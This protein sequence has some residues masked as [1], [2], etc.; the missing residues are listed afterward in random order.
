MPT[1]AQRAEELRRLINYHN[2]KYY[3][4]AAPE[5][6][7]RE[8][9]RLLEDLRK[10][11]A[12]HPE[13]AT[14]DSPT[15]RV[16]G[17][18]IEGFRTVVHRV[19]MLSI[20][21]TY[22]ADDL[23]EFDKRVRKALGKEPVTYVVELKIDGVAIS[24]TYEDGL[25][26]VGATRG[27]GERG[28]DVTHNLK[29]VRDLPLRLHSDHPPSLFEVR[30]EIY[31]TRAELARI[32]RE[33]EQAGEEPY[34][35]PRNLA[36][37]TLKL[38]DPKLCAQRRL[39]L[40][41]Y[42]TGAVEGIELTTHRQMLALL[43]K[44]GF[45][46]NEHIR[47]FDAI[48]GVIDYAMS[49]ATKRN[50]L[51]YEIDGMV[52]KVDD[53]GQRRRL[54]F[55]SKFPRWAVAYKFPAEQAMTRLAEV[56][57][58]VGKSGVLTPRA[59]LDPPVRLAG[60]T[61]RHASLHNEDYMRSKDIRVGDMVVVEKAGEIIPYIVRSEPAARTGKEKIFH[62][63][64]RCPVCGAPVKKDKDGPFYRCTGQDCVGRLKRQLE[65]YAKRNAMDIQDLGEKVVAQL[66]DNGLVQSVPD[67][68]RLKKEDLV[69]LE[70]MG[71]KSAQ[72]LLDGIEASKERGLARLLAGLAIP[73]V[74][75]TVAD[76]LAQEFLSID[77][78]MQ[79]SV[80]RL[81]Q[82]KGIG[83]VIAQSVYDY[84]HSPTGQKVIEEL[85][86]LGVKLT[87]Q[88]RAKAKGG[89]DLTGKTF[90]VTGTLKNYERSEIEGLIRKLG[91]KA[92]GSV[93]KKT[94]Y[95]VAGEAAG[96]KLTKARELG[97]PVLT[98]E[99]FEKLIGK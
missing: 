77:A 68:Y 56:E 73:H 97:V 24:L 66:V 3:V 84:L 21:N 8:F 36:A 25:L 85:R 6:S 55:T 59:H 2:Y 89:A 34:A 19:P 48:D 28:D 29:T 23:K 26:T 93:S 87:E 94:D 37:G 74:G 67:L 57:L 32:N 92:S 61:V 44:F 51:P 82:V 13:L 39:R 79:A 80:E 35:N 88:P 72:N 75:D 96:S 9:D 27:D 64:E 50:E 63:P 90:V 22:N 70:R 49:W 16:G 83:P 95:V 14:P 18:P 69:E 5:I 54:G 65:W 7:D 10:L 98:E 81:S 47:A 12:A 78:M 1:V 40:F 42:G 38:L 31:M 86:E 91:G 15:H 45:Q 20:D 17:Q 4:E 62:W 33:R 11:E 46:V 76:L 53:F 60:T 43:K 30:G 71:D 52:I 58:M 99:E 41:A